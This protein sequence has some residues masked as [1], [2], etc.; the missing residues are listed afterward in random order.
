LRSRVNG[1]AQM[2]VRLLVRSV[3][4]LMRIRVLLLLGFL[5]TQFQAA[6]FRISS[7]DRSNILAWVN[8]FTNGICTVEKLDDNSEPI[9]HQQFGSDQG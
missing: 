1:K 2:M 3:E 5:P 9:H 8:T 4:V 7:F 6:E